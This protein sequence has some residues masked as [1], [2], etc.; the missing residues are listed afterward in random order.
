MTAARKD[1]LLARLTACE[2]H[3]WQLDLDV[4]NEVGQVRKIG[5]LGLNGR[6]PGG[7]RYFGPRANPHGNGSPLPRVTKDAASRHR[8]IKILEALIAQET[9]E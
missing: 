6:T 5:R 8:W 9:P 2:R 3:D 1:D 7:D 4:L